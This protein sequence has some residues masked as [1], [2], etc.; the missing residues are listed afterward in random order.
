[1][2]RLTFTRLLENAARWDV[3]AAYWYAWRD[4]ERGQAVCGWCPW[5]GLIDR[6]GRKKPAYWELRTVA[7]G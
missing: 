6:V 7:R 3:R 2:L 1:M 5:S 4:T